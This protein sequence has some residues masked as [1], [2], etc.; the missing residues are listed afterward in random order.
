MPDPSVSTPA[1]PPAHPFEMTRWQERG[2][3]GVLSAVQFSHIVDF[4]LIMP[5]APQLMRLFTITP[6]EGRRREEN[7]AWITTP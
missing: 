2:L 5:L 1:V 7:V 3:L 6:V 4:M